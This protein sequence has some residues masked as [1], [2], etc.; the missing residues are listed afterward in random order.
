[1]IPQPHFSV[2]RVPVHVQGFFWLL[3][4]WLASRSYTT[5]SLFNGSFHIAEPISF[6][7]FFVIL[8]QAVLMHE[9]GHALV[10][11]V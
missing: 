8:F 2:L 4:F 7:L 3:G 6:V 9:L 5:G 11:C 10:H 1:M